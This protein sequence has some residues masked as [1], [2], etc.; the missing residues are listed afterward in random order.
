M[1]RIISLLFFLI[2]LIIITALAYL[3]SELVHFDYL[4][5]STELPLSVLLLISFILGVLVST[6]SYLGVIYFQKRQLK[7]YRSLK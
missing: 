5:A 4:L 3:N 2:S 1:L 6:I 7:R